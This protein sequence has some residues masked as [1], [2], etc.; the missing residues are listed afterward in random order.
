MPERICNGSVYLA[1]SQYTT[2]CFALVML[3]RVGLGDMYFPLLL[4]FLCACHYW[5]YYFQGRYLAEVIKSFRHL[6]L[7]SCALFFLFG[8]RSTSATS[9]VGGVP[10]CK[11]QLICH[12][13]GDPIL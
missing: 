2:A 1:Q 9:F 6:L 8:Q 10:S 11:S 7:S 13:A 3:L 5:A 4:T 12:P